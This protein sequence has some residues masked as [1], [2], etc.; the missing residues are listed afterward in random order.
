MLVS[1]S[2]D[3]VSSESVSQE[4]RTLQCLSC[5]DLDVR[6]SCL[7]VIS[8][9]K[10]S[11]GTSGGHIALDVPVLYSELLQDLYDGRSCHLIVPEIVL[12][13]LELVEYD[14]VRTALLIK[15]MTLVEDL[16]DV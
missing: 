8:G 10:C 1:D 2:L 9:S 11:A 4:G 13:L 3:P 16:L 14:D 15:F 12:E 6:E 5:S 7:E